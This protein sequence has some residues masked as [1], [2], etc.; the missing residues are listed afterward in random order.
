MVCKGSLPLS[1]RLALQ[2][3]GVGEVRCVL[4]GAIGM[5]GSLTSEGQSN[6]MRLRPAQVIQQGQCIARHEVGGVLAH[7]LGDC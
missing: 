4:L 5:R 6:H 3:N 1:D 7:F 2:L